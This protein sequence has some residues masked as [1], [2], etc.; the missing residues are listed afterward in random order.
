M[1]KISVT[2]CRKDGRPNYGS[3]GASCSIERDVDDELLERPALTAEFIRGMYAIAEAS[4]A[5]KIAS[6]TPRPKIQ[7]MTQAEADAPDPVQA[8][9]NQPPPAA[10]PAPAPSASTPP[11]GRKTYYGNNDAPPKSGKGL[12]AWAKDRSAV[13]WF[14]DLGRK[15]APPLSK[16]LNDWSPEWVSWAHGQYLS[17]CIPAVPSANGNGHPPY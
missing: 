17:A 7:P 16:L 4:V 15:Q 10:T 12:Y 6:S 13:P 5:E 9:V 14:E 1:S 8:R 2:V 3:E 11:P